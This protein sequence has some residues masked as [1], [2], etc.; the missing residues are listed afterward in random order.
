MTI[1]NTPILSPFF[2]IIAWGVLLIIGWRPG[3]TIPKEIKKCVVVAAPH[4]SNWD[5]ALFLPL[6]FAL[7]C[8]SACL[9][10]IQF[11]SA[12]SDGFCDIAVAFR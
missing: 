3:Q 11:S 12:R 10:N 1:F 2:K 5:F 4:T 8:M 7:N 9:L 6:V